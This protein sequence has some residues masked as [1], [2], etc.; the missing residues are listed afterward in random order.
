LPAFFGELKFL[1]MDEDNGEGKE[2]PEGIKKLEAITGGSMKDWVAKLSPEGEKHMILNAITV[3][4]AFQGQGVGSA[5]IEWGAGI[6]DQQGIY[7]WVS[8][9]E[10]GAPMFRGKGFVSHL[11][12]VGE[13]WV[14]AD[15]CDRKKLDGWRWIWMSLGEL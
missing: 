7:C 15:V 1:E 10:A 4:P 8:A 2:K 12:C 6:V 14:G 5:L 3:H 13:K 9:S 11:L